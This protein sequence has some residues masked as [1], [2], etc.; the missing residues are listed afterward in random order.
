MAASSAPPRGAT[1]VDR[2][3]S[4][5]R[6]S[7]A[8]V[9]V[10]VGIGF[11]ALVLLLAWVANGGDERTRPSLVAAETSAPMRQAESWVAA[12]L[13]GHRIVIDAAAA[14]EL[15]EQGLADRQV[16]EIDALGSLAAGPSRWAESQFLVSS[17]ELRARVAGLPDV[18]ST[19]DG[20]MPVAAFG[21]SDERVEVR[22]I[23]SGPPREL[24][25]R[26]VSAEALRLRAGAA[27]ADNPRVVASPDCLAAFRSGRVDERLLSVLA[28][29]SASHELHL[30]ACPA[31][32]GEDEVA[33]PL[34]IVE[35]D[36]VDDGPVSVAGSGLSP[37]EAFVDAQRRVYRPMSVERTATPSGDA[38]LRVTYPV[39]A[40]GTGS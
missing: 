1:P 29:F 8:V 17:P 26:A 2:T 23:A 37:I 13:Q 32:E 20:W 36:R 39:A 40:P 14:R 16:V 31:V 22:R 35:I 10:G 4:A 11:V 5:G 27:L 21:E 12:N 25:E 15:V 38:M 7:D 24:H 18:R 28:T 30:G 33:A 9:V 3:A 19:I 34:R 6:L